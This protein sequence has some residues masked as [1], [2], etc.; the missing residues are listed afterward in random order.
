MFLAEATF[1]NTIGFILCIEQLAMSSQCYGW[2]STRTLL[3]GYGIS[4]LTYNTCSSIGIMPA[5]RRFLNSIHL[6]I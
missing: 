2:L 4:L 6:E 3:V 1:T 5:L